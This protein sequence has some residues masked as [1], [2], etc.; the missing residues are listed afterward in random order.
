MNYRR[1]MYI[2]GLLLLLVLA[3]CTAAAPSDGN[4][5]TGATLVTDEAGS[6]TPFTITAHQDSDLA[7]FDFRGTVTR[8]TIR[9]QILDDAATP[10]WDNAVTGGPFAINTTIRLPKAG[11]YQVRLVWTAPVQLSYSLTWQPHAISAPHLTPVALLPGLGMLGVALGFLIYARHCHA[12]W[13]Y[14]AGGA[15]AWTGTVILKFAWAIPVNPGFY[16]AL[17]RLLPPAL[18]LPLFSL[19]VG[20]LT[21]VFEV[22]I[23]A[24]LV[25]RFR[26]GHTSWRQVLGFGIGFGAIEA[27]V[28]ALSPLLT[29]SL[30]LLQPSVV[31]YQVLSGLQQYNDVL[32]GLAP[33]AERFFMIWVHLCSTVAIFYALA[34]RRSRWFWA[35]FVF[36]SGVDAVAAGA[37]LV[38]IQTVAQLWVVEAIFAVWGVA[39]WIATRTIHARYPGESLQPAPPPFAGEPVHPVP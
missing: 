21:G 8:G 18:T 16:T 15:A 14:I 6:Y 17:E 24:L 27:I 36:K 3:G 22:G 33:V 11:A 10:I 5:I 23:T 12:P 13:R 31:P 30:G 34:T 7:G 37:Q 9:L 19:Y 28:L 4:S 20:A 35:A 1:L 32:M 2:A 25:R 29:V 39:G 26:I 38:G